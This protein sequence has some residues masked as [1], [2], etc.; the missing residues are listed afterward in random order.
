MA[1]IFN[2]LFKTGVRRGT[3]RGLRV[4]AATITT[5]TIIIYNA[6]WS[7]PFRLRVD[8]WQ[9]TNTPPAFTLTL[10]GRPRPR[11]EK[12]KKSRSTITK[13]KHARIKRKSRT[14]PTPHSHRPVEQV[15]RPEFLSSSIRTY[16]Y[17]TAPSLSAR[18]CPCGKLHRPAGEHS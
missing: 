8:L 14:A 7:R 4:T 16:A 3:L 13:K 17:V 15:S 10:V 5:T 12:T 1:T 18:P 2:R 11:A 6:L 9:N